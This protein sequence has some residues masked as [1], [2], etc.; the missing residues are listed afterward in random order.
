MQH[1]DVLV[2]VPQQLRL[3]LED[4][5]VDITVYA[6]VSEVLQFE[7]WPQA[8][9]FGLKT[10]NTIFESLLKKQMYHLCYKWC[11]IV[12]LADTFPQHK[13]LFFSIILDALLNYNEE[14]E[15][16]V[17]LLKIIESFPMDECCNFLAMHKDIFRSVELLQYVINFL[18]KNAKDNENYRNYKVSLIMFEHL[19]QCEREQFWKLLKFPLLIIEQLIMNTKFETLAMILV[20]VRAE[21]QT[22]NGENGQPCAFCYDK[23]GNIY[24]VHTKA[25]SQSH[26]VHFQLGSELA[27]SSHSTFILL[28]FNLYQKDHTIS[29]ECIDLLLRIYATKA[30]D[31]QMFD[32][33]SGTERNS[34]STDMQ[35]SLD[36]LCGAFQMPKTAPMREDWIGDDEAAHCMCC[37]RAVFTMLMRRHHCRRCG[38][39]VC[40]ACSTHRMLIPELYVDVE[41]RFCNDCY[42]FTEEAQRKSTRVSTEKEPVGMY[43]AHEQDI[44]KW[45]LSGNITHDK[46]L[47]EEFCYEHAP[48]VALCLSI[49]NFHLDQKKCVDMLL[50]HCRK[51][52]KLI[53]PNPEVDYELIAKMINCLALA[54]KVC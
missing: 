40:F 37:K 28:N 44:Y 7:S 38:R 15:Q 21:L 32:S 22:L 34:Q 45:K 11:K 24:N 27:R 26:K 13:R 36:S 3:Q 30:L 54:A 48:S 29:N 20:A 9:D 10:P 53:I 5:L 31:Y 41:V 4:T 39:V 33:T 2:R 35:Q 16:N 43:T 19:S 52:E 14:Y 12:K 23:L 25:G 50:Y 1:K 42:N 18:T 17:Y 6:R 46:L 49:L 47:R 51:M 8:Y